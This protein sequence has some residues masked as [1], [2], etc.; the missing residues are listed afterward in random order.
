MCI[1]LGIFVRTKA[2]ALDVVHPLLLVVVSVIWM[3]ATRWIGYS[4]DVTIL[5]FFATYTAMG[6][7][8]AWTIEGRRAHKLVDPVKKDE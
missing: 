1:A 6:I 2:P 5:A 8:I 4:T 7:L 3:T